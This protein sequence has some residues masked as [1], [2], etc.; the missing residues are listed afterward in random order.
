M[1]R[2]AVTILLLLAVLF[3]AATCGNNYDKVFPAVV[4]TWELT[5]SSV[6]LPRFSPHRGDYTKGTDCYEFRQNGVALVPVTPDDKGNKRAVKCALTAT[7]DEL[8]IEYEGIKLISGKYTLIGDTLT[9]VNPDTENTFIFTRVK[10][11]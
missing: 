2:L 9:V 7:V 1:K 3:A 8:T 10:N 11:A 4:G 5:G 6:D